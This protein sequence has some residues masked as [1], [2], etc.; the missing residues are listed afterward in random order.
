MGKVKKTQQAQTGPG[1]T[2]TPRPDTA[3]GRRALALVPP[4]VLSLTTVAPI[5]P[6]ISIDGHAYRISFYED[7][8]TW[9]ALRL[10]KLVAQANEIGDLAVVDE[11]GEIAAAQWEELDRAMLD[12][13]GEMVAIVLP[14]LPEPTRLALNLEQR[15]AIVDAFFKAT[16]TTVGTPAMPQGTATEEG[17]AATSPTGTPSSPPSAPAT[18]GR[19]S[20]GSARRR[21]RTSAPPTAPSPA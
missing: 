15:R 16:G 21:R 6:T 1:G 14:D 11:S 3:I 13:Y 18:A 19:G 5:R 7:F 17:E 8:S 20:T 2:P 12:S 10:G 9:Q 4:T